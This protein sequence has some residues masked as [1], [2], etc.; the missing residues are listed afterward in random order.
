MSITTPPSQ[1]EWP[2]KLWPPPRT[3]SGSVVPAARRG[4]RRSTSSVPAAARDQ[5]RAGG[6]SSRSRPRGARRRPGRRGARARRG[7]RA[8]AAGRSRRRHLRR[9]RWC[10]LPDRTPVARA[11]G[12]S[13]SGGL[14]LG[15]RDAR[16]GVVDARA[17]RRP[18]VDGL[19]P[20]PRR[21]AVGPGQQRAAGARGPC[22]RAVIASSSRTASGRRAGPRRRCV[23]RRR[24]P[25]R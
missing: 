3:A 5:R 14:A 2:G 10:P 9:R 18:G 11:R 24:R 15:R 16:Q 8:R 13:R 12:E 25:G 20:P 1:T 19:R 4:S 17:Q 7:T 21:R 22:A 23:P 6:R